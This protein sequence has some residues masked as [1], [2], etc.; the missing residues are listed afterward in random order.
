MKPWSTAELLARCP[1]APVNPIKAMDPARRVQGRKAH[2]DGDR[3]EKLV[4]ATLRINNIPAERLETGWRV[5]RQFAAGKTRIV[6]AT[7]KAKVLAD[8]LGVLNQG[9]SLLIEVKSENDDR[10]S[11]SRL[12]AHQI[13][14]LDRWHLAGAFV[15]VAWV[16]AHQI[17]LIR[18]RPDATNWRPGHPISWAVA[19]HINVMPEITGR[20]QLPQSR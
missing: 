7:P 2:A 9:R 10:L 8:I 13:D 20:T 18:W 16:R 17:A 11:W 12:D 14:N 5:L 3:A 1:V 15:A 4:I 6:S 19:Q